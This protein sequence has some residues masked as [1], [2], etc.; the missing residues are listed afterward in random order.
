VS[1]WRRGPLSNNPYLRTAFRVARVTR[2][3]TRRR[4]IASMIA[5]TRNLL[6]RDPTA[7]AIAGRPVTQEELNSAEKTLLNAEQRIAEELLHH[8]TEQ[9]P[10]DRLRKCL[11]RCTEAMGGQ[12][13]AAPSAP[14]LRGLEPWILQLLERFHKSVESGDGSFGALELTIPSPFGHFDEP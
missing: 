11:E 1:I 13:A 7:H 4:T 12:Q 10:V 8:Q 3:T 2:E 9:Y 5:Q 6:K 14:N